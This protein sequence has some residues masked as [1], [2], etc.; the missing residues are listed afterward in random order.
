MKGLVR[1]ALRLALISLLGML[2]TPYVS[3]FFARLAERAP[4]DSVAEEIF[5]EL[6]DELAGP[7]ITALATAVSEVMLGRGS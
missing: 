7:L 3:A 2:V 6:R 4:D 1:T 5:I